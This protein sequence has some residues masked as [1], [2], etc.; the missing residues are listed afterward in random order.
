MALHNDSVSTVHW[1]AGTSRHQVT[2]ELSTLLRL[3]YFRAPTLLFAWLEDLSP[4]I[5]PHLHAAA[6]T[7]K[8]TNASIVSS[9]GR[10]P[11]KL[12]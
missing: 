3:C 6:K 5:F 9:W 2:V 10:V 12:I 1:D 7:T 11:G 8:V 4:Q